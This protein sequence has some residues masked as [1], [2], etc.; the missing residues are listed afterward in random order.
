MTKM[1]LKNCK[2]CNKIFTS[3]AKSCPYC[4]DE[5]TRSTPDDAKK[6]GLKQV[7]VVFIIILVFY[8]LKHQDG[9][10]H[11]GAVM[12]AAQTQRES[13]I[14]A[15]C[16]VGT[17]A[18]TQTVLQQPYF[19]CK[20]GELSDYANFVLSVMQDQ[21]QSDG[22]SPEI[23][24]D[25]GEPVVQ[26]RDLIRLDRY[27]ARAG[28]SSFEEAIA[29]CYKGIGGLK[30]VVLS[31]PMKSASI[32]VREEDNVNNKFWLSKAALDKL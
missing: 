22:Y 11:E 9:V 19:T 5:T 32:Y 1:V 27:R 25:T 13:C 2:K 17:K 6:M 18:V 14:S 15:Q 23:S 21:L 8:S 3:D 4:G 10:P 31:N 28:V 20:T 29:Q 7:G 30:V 26:G 24:A 16:P 12:T